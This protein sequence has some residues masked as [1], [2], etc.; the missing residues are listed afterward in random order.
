MTHRIKIYRST[1][2]QGS[3]I[4]TELIDEFDVC[5]IPRNLQ[6]LAEIVGGD[7]AV[8]ETNCLEETKQW[9]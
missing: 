6:N 9:K 4:S 1:G 2:R 5:K 7:F 8:I 3:I